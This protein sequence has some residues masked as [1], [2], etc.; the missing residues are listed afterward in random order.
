VRHFAECP[1][2]PFG[3]VAAVKEFPGVWA[4]YRVFD[5]GVMQVVHRITGPDVDPWIERTRE[6]Y[7]TL[8]PPSDAFAT[9]WPR[10][11]LGSIEER[12][13]VVAMVDDR[14]RRLPAT[15]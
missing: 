9:F 15:P 14:G 5:G 6:L 8:K 4:E 10:L 7:S 3:E 13:F 11:S 2:V 1:D 12:C